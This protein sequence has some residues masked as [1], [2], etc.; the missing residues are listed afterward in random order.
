MQTTLPL[1]AIQPKR[2]TLWLALTSVYILWGSTYLFIHFM[3]EQMPPLYMSSLRFLVAGTILYSYARLTGTPRPTWSQVRSAGIVGILLL[4][5]ANGC[6]SMALQHIPTSIAALLAATM[7][8]F[9]LS[10]NW[11]GFAKTRPTNLALSGLLLGFVGICFLIKPD[12]M[13]ATRTTNDN[14]IGAG[15]VMVA[16][17]AW[18]LGTLLSPRLPLPSQII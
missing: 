8:V 7:P 14:L 10:L 9:L 13:Y 1:P 18:A 3:T 6:L 12:N 11:L 5:I 4:T 16:N 17:V 15:L 2:L